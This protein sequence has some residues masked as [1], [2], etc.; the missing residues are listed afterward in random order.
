[1]TFSS[2]LHFPKQ[3]APICPI[4]NVAV[5]L[6]RAKTDENGRAVHEDYYVLALKPLLESGS[7]PRD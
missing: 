1:M 2:K 6:D 5:P 4:C 3:M 7:D